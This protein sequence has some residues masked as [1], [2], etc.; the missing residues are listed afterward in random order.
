MNPNENPLPYQQLYA[1]AVALGQEVT[2]RKKRGEEGWV[3]WLTQD[4]IK[5]MQEHNKMFMVSNFME[6]QIMR[7]YR[8]P[9]PDVD[10]KFMKF[11]Y[12]SEIMEKIGYCPALSRHLSLQ[13]LNTV[14]T[15]LGFKKVHRSTGN[16]WIVIE[17]QEGEQNSEAIVSPSELTL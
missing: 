13:N 6:D 8:V 4:D 9:E 5:Q 10:T 11:R 15:N 3:Y 12:S 17:K 2:E 1:Q 7:F 14:M 16:G